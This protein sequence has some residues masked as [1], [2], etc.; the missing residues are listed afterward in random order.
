MGQLFD[1]FLVKNWS[2]WPILAKFGFLV[3]FGSYGVWF[4]LKVAQVAA[5]ARMTWSRRQTA[6]TRSATPIR[7]RPARVAKGTL[8]ISTGKGRRAQVR[9]GPISQ[10]DPCL[11]SDPGRVGK[12]GPAHFGQFL[13][14]I[15]HFSNFW[16]QKI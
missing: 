14:K 9:A 8:N 2:K 11:R 15:G 10:E 13:T 4:G 1:Q 7:A 12:I 6:R 5:S 3:K 16:G